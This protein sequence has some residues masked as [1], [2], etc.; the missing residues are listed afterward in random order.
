MHTVL[1]PYIPECLERL[2]EQSLTASENESEV[3]DDDPF[4]TSGMIP[5]TNEEAEYR[6]P[7]L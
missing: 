6:Y 4:N 5:F 7:V 1:A 2:M 3:E